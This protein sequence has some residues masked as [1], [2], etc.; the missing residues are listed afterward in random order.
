MQRMALQ[1][2]PQSI[3]RIECS[4]RYVIERTPVIGNEVLRLEALEQSERVIARQ[5]SFAETGLPPRSMAD[6]QECQIEIPPS[7]HQLP[8]HHIR[9]IGHQRRISRKETRHF[10]SIEQIHIR[11]AAPSV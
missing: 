7:G 11:G 1:R 10:I 5:M 9:G 3:N 6:W 2:C 4:R 8:L